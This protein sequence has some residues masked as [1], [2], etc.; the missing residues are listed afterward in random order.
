MLGV[1]A[2]PPLFDAQNH[3]GFALRSKAMGRRQPRRSR[4]GANPQP[5]PFFPLRRRPTARPPRPINRAAAVTAPTPPASFRRRM[6]SSL[7]FGVQRLRERH[8]KEVRRVEK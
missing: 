1:A 4:P 5:C 6:C 7:L 3:S 8:A 2:R